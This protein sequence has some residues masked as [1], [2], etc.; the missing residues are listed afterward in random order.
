VVQ[1][2]MREPVGRRKFSSD[3]IELK[4]IRDWLRKILQQQHCSKSTI[5]DAILAIN[6]ACMNIIQHAYYGQVDGNII[7]EIFQDTDFLTFHLT[8]FAP[9]VDIN[10]CHPRNLD[11]LRPGGLGLHIIRSIMDEVQSLPPP[12]DAGNLL[13]LKLNI[14]KQAGQG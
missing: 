9:P 8:D 4:T 7:I 1:L 5:D 10:T 14:H 13:E 2:S 11:E 12:D 6:E 3:S